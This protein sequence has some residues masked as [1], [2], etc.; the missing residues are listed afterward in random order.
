MSAQFLTNIPE[1]NKTP[2][3][4]DLLDFIQLQK[5]AIQQ[6]KDE[7]AILKKQKPKPKI[8]PSK[9]DKDTDKDGKKRK[10]KK[11]TKKRFKT[12]SLKIDNTVIV[13]P[14][15]IPPGSTFVE[16][17]DYTVQ[18]IVFSCS[19]TCY[20]RAR[21]KTPD[22]KYITGEL[23]KSINGHFGSILVSYVLYQ[24]HHCHATQPLIAE[25]L[26]E[27][28]VDISAGQLSN[29][30]TKN[31]SKF[32]I[33]KDHILETGLNLSKYI[34]TDDTAARHNG[35]NGYCTHIGN[36]YFAW[37]EST[38]SK[39]RINFL[40]LLRG[41]HKDYVL[42]YDALE[43]MSVQKLPQFQLSK[44][45]AL[46]DRVFK[47]SD[48]WYACC[49]ALEI[50]SE[51]HLRIATEGGLV[52]SIIFHGFNKDLVIISDDAGQ[53]NVF[54]HGLCWVHAERTIHKLIGHS[55]G[56]KKILEQTRK[57]IWELYND[58]K[59]YRL[60]PD[61]KTALE[62]TNRFD[63]L[64]TRKTNFASL[65]NAL[66]RIHNNKTELLLVIV[67]PDIPLHN[68]LSES[69]IREYA[70]RRKV[71]GSTR[72]SD[73]KKSRDT[74]TSL[75]K[76]CRKLGVSFW[77]YLNDRVSNKDQIPQLAEIMKAKMTGSA[78]NELLPVPT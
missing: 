33:E 23:P 64:F 49:V 58:L 77:N 47:D 53:F 56:H 70:K 69:D 50:N 9:L 65:N 59:K 7:I 27:I 35:N 55:K 42:S 37:F 34:N 73:G 16:Y 10:K 20:R 74:F 19:N 46:N 36:E 38:S 5:E 40:Q 41:S 15:N 62:L 63:E 48:E 60:S 2:L 17:K 3:V 11:R 72:S 32:H 44:L 54:L 25:Q 51:R 13:E 52:G 61:M 28:G 18:D 29:I 14:E 21:Y 71:S 67:R 4:V 24:Y 12:K 45:V 68:N 57:D 26:H 30:I 8:K 39:S 31:K 76:T 66:K 1:K 6:L 43:Y 22:G 78:E 75:K